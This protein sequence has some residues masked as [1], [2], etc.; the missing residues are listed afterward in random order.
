MANNLC[1][2][3]SKGHLPGEPVVYSAQVLRPLEMDRSHVHALQDRIGASMAEEIESM[4]NRC[5]QP[6][7]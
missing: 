5:T 6:T 4:V 3:I 7:A 2:D 1:K